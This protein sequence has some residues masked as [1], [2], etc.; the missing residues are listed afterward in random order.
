MATAVT[1]N[2]IT[3]LLE[4]EDI[5]S[6]E[7]AKIHWIRMNKLQDVLSVVVLITGLLLVQ[8][9]NTFKNALLKMKSIL[10]IK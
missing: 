9:C 1:Q 8:M 5:L 10:I 2:L 3:N 7:E 6:R 4:E